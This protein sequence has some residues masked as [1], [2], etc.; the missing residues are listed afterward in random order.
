MIKN[1]WQYKVTLSRIAEF[2]KSLAEL[3]KLPASKTQPWLRKAQKE[4]L[5]VQIRDFRK[6]LAEYD[7][8]RSGKTKLPDLKTIEAI[9]SLLI[10]WRIA[11]GL[12]Q[13]DLAHLMGLKKQ[14]IQRYE[15]RDY[16][17]ATLET[18]FRVAAALDNRT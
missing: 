10:K 1:E 4:S 18:I 13:E 2:K 9:P 6:Q 14:Q 7:A 11:K 3:K 12:N 8:L 5:L 16:S 15:Q 17:T